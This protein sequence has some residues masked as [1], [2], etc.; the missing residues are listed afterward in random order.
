MLVELWKKSD[1]GGIITNSASLNI[2]KENHPCK[3]IY[4]EHF[5]IVNIVVQILTRLILQLC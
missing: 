2:Q 4:F 3:N 5:V 1:L